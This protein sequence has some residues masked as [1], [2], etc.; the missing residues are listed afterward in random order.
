MSIYGQKINL[1]FDPMNIEFRKLLVDYFNNP[2]MTKVTENFN[3]YAVYVVCV[4]TMLLSDKRYVIVNSPKDEVE[5]GGTKKLSD[6]K[7][8]ILQTKEIDGTFGVPLKNVTYSVRENNCE[9]FLNEINIVNRT[10]E[11]TEYSCKGYDD[12]SITMIHKDKFLYEF[13]DNATLLSAI[14]KYSTLIFI[15][16]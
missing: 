5:I 4:K 12:I 14:E 10:T 13:P 16:N 9:E 6:L 7:F 8:K 2:T 15:K 3:N 1:G 11:T